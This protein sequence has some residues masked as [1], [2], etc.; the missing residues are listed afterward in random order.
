[1]ISSPDSLK[2]LRHFISATGRNQHGNALAQHLRLGIAENLLRAG[3]PTRN[4]SLQRR[5]DDGI[6]GR[7]NDGGESGCS[8]LDLLPFCHVLTDACG[9][10]YPSRPITQDR[11]V[12]MNKPDLTAPGPYGILLVCGK[13]RRRK[14]IQVQA[15]QIRVFF[16]N[17]FLKPIYIDDVFSPPVGQREQIIVA[18][19]DLAVCIQCNCQEVDGLEH[20]TEPA[21]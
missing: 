21:F 19:C 6:L 7:L 3:I 17:E 5:A 15:P 9:A 12:P 1:M 4:H 11:V 13:R 2:N 10:D 16:R 18:K 8:F 20:L 14:R